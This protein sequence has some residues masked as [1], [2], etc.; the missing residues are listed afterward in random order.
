MGTDYRI[1]FSRRRSIGIVIRPDKEVV[2]RAPYGASTKVIEKF[3]SE[4]EEW[5]KKHITKYSDTIQLNSSKKYVDGE[6]YLF[7]GRE[8]TLRIRNSLFPSIKQIDNILEAETDG[9]D[10]RIKMLID[11]WYHKKAEEI[12]SEKLNEILIKHKEQDF[13]P[14]QLVVRTL[15]SR[16]GSCTSKGKI[17]ISSD[18]VKL[19]EKFI[20]YVIIHELCH[21]KHH[22]HGKD[23]YRLLEMLIPDYN[24]I[25]KELRKYS[26]S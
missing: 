19:D 8:L 6:K 18:L 11:R 16:W 20:E 2:V 25:R 23:Y 15:K 24:A 4:K 9:K 10:G 14:S 17:T 21:L 12:F 13:S 3:V 22:N 26:L 5:I 1:I 7:L